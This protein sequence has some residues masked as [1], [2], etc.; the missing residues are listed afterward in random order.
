MQGED[1]AWELLAGLDPQDV[2]GRALADFDPVAGAYVLSVFGLPVTVAPERRTIGGSCPD[3]DLILKKMAYFS[4]LSILHYLIGAQ[5]LPPAGQLVKP[6]ELK[7][8]LLYFTG[9]HVLP[10]DALA[11]RYGRDAAGFLSQGLRFGGQ[12]RSYGDAAVELLPF[13]RLSVTLV[14]WRADDE[15]AARADLMF[16]ATCERHVPA[17]ILWSIA[18]L[19]VK[20]MLQG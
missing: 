18:M 14:L 17:D 9:S 15:F 10:L 12:R 6:A 7:V 3:C 11:A 4:R 8:G 13:P 19:S 2:C 5:A 16:D 1:R 20:V